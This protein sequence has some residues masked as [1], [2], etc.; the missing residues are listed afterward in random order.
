ME[1]NYLRDQLRLY[2]EVSDESNGTVLRVRS[3]GPMISFSQP[4]AQ[5]DRTSRLHVL[6]QSGATA[7]TYTILS[8]EG[9]MVQQEVYDYVTTRPRLGQDTDGNI[10]VHGGVRRV[11]PGEMPQIKSPDQ[12]AR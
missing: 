5:L 10:I 1:A 6:C 12:L 4:E 11:E 3:I 8:T 2:V 7:F 9:K